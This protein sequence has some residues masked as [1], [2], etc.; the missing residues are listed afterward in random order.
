MGFSSSTDKKQINMGDLGIRAVS[1]DRKYVFAH[2]MM[3]NTYPYHPH[4]F[5]KD[6]SDAILTGIDGFALN[7]GQDEWTSSRIDTIFSV[8]RR[9]P[10][11]K[12]FFSF[13]MSIITSAALIV[14]YILRYAEHPNSFQYRGRYFVST[15]SGESQSFGHDDVNQGWEKEVRLPLIQKGLEICFVPSWTGY[16]G[17][18]MFK[19]FPVVDGAFSW[20]AW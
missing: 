3:G 7:I 16:D 6:I 13:D 8:V 2:F 15:F 10:E 17:R 14:E 20:A 5:E 1:L 18:D 4:H 9:F 19:R 12:L 11:F